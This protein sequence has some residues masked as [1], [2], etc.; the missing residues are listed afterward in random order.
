MEMNGREIEFKEGSGGTAADR[1]FFEMPGINGN[2]GKLAA[3]DVK[4]HEGDVVHRA[5]RA[6]SDG[7]A[8]DRPAAW[9]SWAIWT[10][11]STPWM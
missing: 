11:S 3:Y 7:G 5:A 6:V 1:R 10:V 4:T 9:R 2:I 8:I